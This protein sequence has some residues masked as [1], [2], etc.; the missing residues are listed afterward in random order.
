MTEPSIHSI[1][2]ETSVDNSLMKEWKGIY[3]DFIPHLRPNKKSAAEV[4]AYIE[5]SYPTEAETSPAAQKV[6]ALNAQSYRDYLPEDS[7]TQDTIPEII[8]LKVKNEGAGKRLYDR[9][10]QDY[11]DFFA[12]HKGFV[13]EL[14]KPPS[15]QFPIPILVG[16]EKHSSFVYVEGS[17]TLTDEIS[18]FQGLNERE[19]TNIYLVAQYIQILKKYNRLDSVLNHEIP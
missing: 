5:N 4:L 13:E 17:P 10:Q 2:V 12:E 11:T 15:E 1:V 16:V 14:A 9:Q 6:V 18:L 19:L 8:I 3:D 7:F